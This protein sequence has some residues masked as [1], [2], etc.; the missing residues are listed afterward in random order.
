MLNKSEEIV[1]VPGWNE[2]VEDVVQIQVQMD[3]S[4]L[5]VSTFLYLSNNIN[6]SQ[7][8]KHLRWTTKWFRI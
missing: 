3:K 6:L 4:K 8:G 1:I 2:D 7:E 5:Y